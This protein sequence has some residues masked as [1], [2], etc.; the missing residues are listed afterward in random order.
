MM[1]MKK[2]TAKIG[3]TQLALVKLLPICVFVKM[4]IGLSS[5][6]ERDI[7]DFKRTVE[8]RRLVIS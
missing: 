4:S 8:I 5:S 6:L 3:N 7:N 1:P 2:E